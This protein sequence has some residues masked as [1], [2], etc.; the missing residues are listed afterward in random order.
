MANNL[1]NRDAYIIMGI[2]DKPIKIT[3]VKQFS[4]KWTQ[5]KYQ[6][7]F[8]KFNLGWRYDSDS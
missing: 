4:N 6:D 2:Q 3:G 8:T 7:F 1:S 5:E